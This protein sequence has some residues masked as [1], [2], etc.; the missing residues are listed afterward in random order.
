MIKNNLERKGFI[1]SYGLQFIMEGSQVRNSRQEPRAGSEADVRRKSCLLVCFS[2]LAQPVF[3][4]HWA[5]RH[6]W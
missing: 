3:L 4:Q 2:W 6:P 5:D 1:L